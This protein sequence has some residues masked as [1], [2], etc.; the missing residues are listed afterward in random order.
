M[1]LETPLHEEALVGILEA[2]YEGAPIENLNRRGVKVGAHQNLHE[3]ALAMLAGPKI[4]RNIVDILRMLP[5]GEVATTESEHL[6]EWM[7]MLL[8]S[9]GLPTDIDW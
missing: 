4:V 3:T 1:I 5:S 7:T 2:H 6:R 8:T 9:G